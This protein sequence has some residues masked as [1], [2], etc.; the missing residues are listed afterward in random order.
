MPTRR[1]FLLTLLLAGWTYCCGPAAAASGVQAPNVVPISAQLV[2]SGQ[3]TAASLAQLAE[4]GFGAV[5]YLAPL[6]VPDAIADEPAIVRGQGMEFVHIPIQF[7]KP[8]DADVQAFVAAMRR[9]RGSKVLVHCQINMR[10][11]SLTFLYRVL[12]A[13]EAPEQAYD[14]VTRVWSPQGVWKE[15]LASQLAKAGIDFDPY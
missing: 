12:E 7:G 4:Q 13:H 8:T 11:S 3:P 14:S 10:A 5:I 2:T 1:A 6:T 9:L 15:L